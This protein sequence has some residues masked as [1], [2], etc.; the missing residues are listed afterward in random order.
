MLV[1]PG[2]K[3]GPPPV[4]YGRTFF[5]ALAG[6]LGIVDY[7]VGGIALLTGIA[8]YLPAWT[9]YEFNT[10]AKKQAKTGSSNLV[11]PPRNQI[12]RKRKVFEVWGRMK[13]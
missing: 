3:F 6:V 7:V 10:S 4:S 5:R 2:A 12:R 13:S 8:G 11:R 1:E 9:V